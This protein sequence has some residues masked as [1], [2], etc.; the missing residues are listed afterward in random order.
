MT[1]AETALW[2]E[3]LIIDLRF[4]RNYHLFC[5]RGLCGV[6]TLSLH[7]PR[8][9]WPTSSEF[10]VN[11]RWLTPLLTNGGKN[12]TWKSF[13]MAPPIFHS[14]WNNIVSNLPKWDIPFWKKLWKSGGEVRKVIPVF[15][16][17]Y[18]FLNYCIALALYHYYK[19]LRWWRY[20]KQCCIKCTWRHFSTAP[21]L[22]G[23]KKVVHWPIYVRFDCFVTVW[24]Q[25]WRLDDV[26]A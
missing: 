12:N 14:I 7:L 6:L 25:R 17:H 19:P 1:Q 11:P 18:C 4:D 22:W 9:W 13:R 3:V 10:Q 15:W 21:S 2:C 16:Y 23:Q 20:I 8:L 5:C 24:P 26:N